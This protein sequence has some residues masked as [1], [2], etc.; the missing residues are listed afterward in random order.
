MMVIV[1]KGC[2][3]IAGVGVGSGDEFKIKMMNVDYPFLR[4]KILRK[5]K[6][7]PFIRQACYIQNIELCSKLLSSKANNLLFS[8]L[9]SGLNNIHSFHIFGKYSD[10]AKIS[11]HFNE[12][13][14]LFSSLKGR[15]LI[16]SVRLKAKEFV[17]IILATSEVKKI[18][19]HDCCILEG[20]IKRQ[21]MGSSRLK[22]IVFSNPREISLDGYSNF[23]NYKKILRN[24]SYCPCINSLTNITLSQCNF[25]EDQAK[26]IKRKY[27]FYTTKFI[28]QDNSGTKI[29]P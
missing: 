25:K 23:V 21:L 2:L 3:W 5:F 20:K 28:L 17:R 8:S 9:S 18:F 10:K 27:G 26:S 11:K 16:S 24:I 19:F 7:S 22:N 29:I 4:S 12:F 14:K 13:I 1:L 15:L 6:Y